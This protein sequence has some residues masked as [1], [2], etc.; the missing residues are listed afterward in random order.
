MAQRPLVTVREAGPT[1]LEVLV[2]FNLA[3][4]LE[5]EGK[6]LDRARLASG[7]ASVFQDRAKG[8]YL[9]AEVDARA[10]GSLLITYEWSD[11]RNATFWWVQSV[12]VLPAARRRGVYSAM[13]RWV[14]ETA[15][16][17]PKPSRH[18][19]ACGIRLYVDRDN[20]VAKKTYASLGMA[21]SRY[22]MVEMDF[23]YPE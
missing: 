9:V 13:H 8:F 14:Y 20:L 23:V 18:P 4:S 11:W 22:E 10:V 15:S 16:R 19:E 17:H 5:T 12:Y 6:A 3:M 1:D 2:S 7:I 21:A